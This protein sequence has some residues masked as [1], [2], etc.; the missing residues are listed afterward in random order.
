MGDDHHAGAENQTHAYNP[1]HGRPD[2]LCL[3]RTVV[4]ADDRLCPQGK[5]SHGH[6]D[7]Q[8]IALDDG[9]AG[10][11]RI[12]LFGPSVMLENG[13]EHNEEYAVAGNNEKGRQA[14]GEYT[15]HHPP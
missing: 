10:H 3:P 8:Q 4:K 6:G 1:L 14:K 13:V 2:A 11:Q 12:P 5:S 15:H 9:R 7:D